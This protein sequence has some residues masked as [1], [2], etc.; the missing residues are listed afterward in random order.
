MHLYEKPAHVLHDMLTRG[1]ISAREL[2]EDV[3]ARM[4]AVEPQIGA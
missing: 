2:T 1:E 4:D 3:L